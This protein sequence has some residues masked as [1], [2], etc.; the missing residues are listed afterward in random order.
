[1]AQSLKTLLFH[2]LD[3]TIGGY[4][5]GLHPEN[6][7]LGIWSGKLELRN[8][9]LKASALNNKLKLPQCN[10]RNGSIES[11]T[12]VI[13]W[14][15]LGSSPVQID[16]KGVTALVSTEATRVDPRALREAVRAR[17]SA[18][19]AAFVAW[20]NKSK[21]RLS[22]EKRSPGFLA[23]YAAKIVDNIEVSIR[24]VRLRYEDDRFACGLEVASFEACAANAAWERAFV[25][26]NAST[27]IRN[28]A[29]VQGLALYCR[30]RPAKTDDD[31]YVLEPLD[32]ALRATRND[33][34]RAGNP[35]YRVELSM[36]G[37]T[38]HARPAVVQAARSLAH[39]LD[40][41]SRRGRLAR[42]HP[43]ALLGAARARPVSKRNARAWW[44]YA[45]E[46]SHPALADARERRRAVHWP[47]EIARSLRVR[48]RYVEL[49][50]RAE[51]SDDAEN[52]MATIELTVPFSAVARWRQTVI[53]KRDL[54]VS[55]AE[56][57]EEE[58]KTT[59][60]RDESEEAT[61]ADLEAIVRQAEEEERNARPPADFELLRF[62][63]HGGFRCFV[64]D[65]NAGLP[66]LECGV[67]ASAFAR[68]T[69]DSDLDV[70]AGLRNLYVVT[71][72]SKTRLATCEAAEGGSWFLRQPANVLNATACPKSLSKDAEAA[73]AIN[74][75]PAQLLVSRRKFQKKSHPAKFRLSVIARA[76]S[77]RMTY[78]PVVHSVFD[79]F[80]FRDDDDVPAP[81]KPAQSVKLASSAFRRAIKQAAAAEPLLLVD[82]K[83]G[84]PTFIFP[85]GTETAFVVET[86]SLSIDGDSAET[87]NQT[88]A[89][90][91]S[92]ARVFK[93]RHAS[94]NEE[95]VFAPF[96][97]SIKVAQQFSERLV[98]D[99]LMEVPLC[100]LEAIT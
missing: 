64:Y 90:N 7:E 6:L 36:D 92:N 60:P 16:I 23:R 41:V 98:V 88:W 25:E 70:V 45:A 91:T 38:L 19:D 74:G 77:C 68:S 49:F 79:A 58:E 22:N 37:A 32:V 56:D 5:E 67:D 2:V 3:S 80:T 8:L 76:T 12:V 1:M 48:D 85:A 72:S 11:L 69:V 31:E 100:E 87:G 97:V 95:T 94:K 53:A 29:R 10:V 93:Q 9:A 46:M 28:V 43:A 47:L 42:R 73:A 83:L 89:I 63:A 66:L 61:M 39:K 65:D 51:R 33:R 57:D 84:T 40:L 96:G 86:G 52:D 26:R 55:E 62:S 50:E 82:V 35:R 24:A 18:S 54:L 27:L 21:K 71:P 14:N 99:P 81:M 13:P 4:V 78:A 17:L 44:K 30:R 20:L 59:S 15:R 75:L 34:D